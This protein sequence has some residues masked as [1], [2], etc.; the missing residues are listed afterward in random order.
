MTIENFK[1]AVQYNDYVGSISADGADMY[2]FTTALRK[3][4]LITK[5]EFVVGVDFSPAGL[6]VNSVDEIFIN[7]Y[8]V[9]NFNFEEF[10][11]SMNDGQPPELRKITQD[12]TVKDFFNQF[13]RLN[14]KISWKGLLDGI[15]IKTI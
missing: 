11:A 14:A 10:K 6:T 12:I 3:Q 7:Y 13:K 8:V 15:D 9:D 5:D 1:A 2:D 4:D